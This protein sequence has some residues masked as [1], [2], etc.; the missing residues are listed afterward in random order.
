MAS[1]W[2]CD[3]ELSG[4]IRCRGF[5]SVAEGLLASQDGLCCV[6]NENCIFILIKFL[7]LKH[8]GVKHHRARVS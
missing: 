5:F 2:E 1:L 8:T 4:S 7:L 3:N 6:A